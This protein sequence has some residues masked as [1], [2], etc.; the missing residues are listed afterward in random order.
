MS[1]RNERAHIHI[2]QGDNGGIGQRTAAVIAHGRRRGLAL[3]PANNE[4]THG[5]QCPLR[6]N[7]EYEDNS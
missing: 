2:P 5:E 6:E 1:R 7:R 3:P 4:D